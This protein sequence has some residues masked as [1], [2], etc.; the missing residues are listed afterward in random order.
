M[1]GRLEA[2]RPF[3]SSQSWRHW[4][5]AGRRKAALIPT[6]FSGIPSQREISFTLLDFIHKIA[7]KS[8]WTQLFW[9]ATLPISASGQQVAFRGTESSRVSI[10]LHTQAGSNRARK[11]APARAVQTPAR[12]KL[13]WTC[14]THSLLEHGQG[15]GTPGEGRCWGAG[16]VLVGA[17]PPP[18][19]SCLLPVVSR[20]KDPKQNGAQFLLELDMR[21][22]ATFLICP[23]AFHYRDSC[24]SSWICCRHWLGTTKLG[25]LQLHP[26]KL[27]SLGIKIQVPRTDLVLQPILVF[28]R[29]KFC[30]PILFNL[31]LITCNLKILR[32][33]S[34][35][36][37]T[38]FQQ[39]IS[40]SVNMLHLRTIRV[41]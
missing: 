27:H 14:H 5:R 19:A 26:S 11:L 40:S 25:Y 7:W 15:W 29:C 6:T 23:Q 18:G 41:L 17:L 1:Q 2:Y 37:Y 34:F 21:R 38:L 30:L 16:V 31:F 33:L 22:K 12:L 24:S 9:T 10:T 3:T 28:R 39:N 35:L 32:I 4:H 36:P 20:K 13:S 8:L